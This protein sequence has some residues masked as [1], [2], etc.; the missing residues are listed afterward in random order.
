MN[1]VI[2]GVEYA[3]KVEFKPPTD[4]AING[5]LKALTEIIYFPECS[6]KHIS[7][8]FDALNSI[9]PELAEIASDDPRAAFIAVHPGFED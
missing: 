6:N 7:W 5:C 3:P 9:N 1:V 8:A 4:K 2:D